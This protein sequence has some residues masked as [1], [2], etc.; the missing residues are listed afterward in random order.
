MLQKKGICKGTT[1]TRKPE[2][3]ISNNSSP[4]DLRN[5]GTIKTP[6]EK[7]PEPAANKKQKISEGHAAA[8]DPSE[9]ACD[10]NLATPGIQCLI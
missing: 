3:D 5:I 7:L 10:P 9:K 4:Q 6:D 2:I 1:K 8:S